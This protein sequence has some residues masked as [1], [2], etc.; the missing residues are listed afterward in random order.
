MASGKGFHPR[1]CGLADSRRP[2]VLC[3]DSRLRV[4]PLGASASRWCGW[5]AHALRM[6]R[7][8]LTPPGGAVGELTPSGCFG[9]GSRLQVVPVGR[10]LPSGGADRRLTPPDAS[11]ETW[12]SGEAQGLGWRRGPPVLRR[13]L[14]PP[15]VLCGD[16]RLRCRSSEVYASGGAGE[17]MPSPGVTPGGRAGRTARSPSARSRLAPGKVVSGA[18]ERLEISRYGGSGRHAWLRYGRRASRAGYSPPGN[19]PSSI[20]AKSS[21]LVAR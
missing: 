20:S 16:I 17:G 5:R 18:G 9:G 21:S 7:R 6:L 19:T 8:R 14:A 4:V 11:V 13:R 10:R 15:N 12:V 3:G 1:R 2:N